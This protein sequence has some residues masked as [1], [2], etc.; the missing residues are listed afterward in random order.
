MVIVY[1]VRHFEKSQIWVSKILISHDIPVVVLD[2][3][4]VPMK[5]LGCILLS[6]ARQEMSEELMGA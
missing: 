5:C 4:F 6:V 3:G 1:G 2:V